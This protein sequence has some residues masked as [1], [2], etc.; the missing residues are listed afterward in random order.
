MTENRRMRWADFL[1][2]ASDLQLV[3]YLVGIEVLKATME[4]VFS[5][6]HR[7]QG[8]HERV[9]GVDRNPMV[10]IQQYR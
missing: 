7:T 4:T 1:A 3:P 5:A 9:T 6:T 2:L 10:A 8:G